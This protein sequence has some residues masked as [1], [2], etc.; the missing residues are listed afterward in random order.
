MTQSEKETMMFLVDGLIAFG[1]DRETT[2]LITAAMFR[3]PQRA[4]ALMCF[5]ATNPKATP[6][7]IEVKSAAILDKEIKST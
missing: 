1:L 5:M 6:N 4:Q 2:Y 3:R 7:E